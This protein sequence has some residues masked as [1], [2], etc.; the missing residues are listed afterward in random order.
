MKK[1]EGTARLRADRPALIAGALVRLRMSGD[2]RTCG[3]LNAQRT[4]TP[5][6]G[7]AMHVVADDLRRYIVSAP[8]PLPVP[9]RSDPGPA[10]VLR[11]ST[12]RLRR[13]TESWQAVGSRDGESQSKK[14]SALIDLID[15][16]IPCIEHG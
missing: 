3:D 8:H 4:A 1:Y 16:V 9:P 14:T 5:R 7:R 13:T 6:H 12:A 11:A 2:E 10:D 15:A